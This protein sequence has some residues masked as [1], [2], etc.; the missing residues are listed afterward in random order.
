MNP[1]RMFWLMIKL[2]NLSRRHWHIA[3]VEAPKSPVDAAISIQGIRGLAHVH[4]CTSEVH[5]RVFR[6]IYLYSENHL[7]ATCNRLFQN[8]KACLIACVRPD[9]DFVKV[10]CQLECFDVMLSGTDLKWSY[11]LNI[12]VLSRAE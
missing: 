8:F 11:L 7:F 2:K 9:P 5:V 6:L 3:S 1:K 4:S 12:A 10:Q